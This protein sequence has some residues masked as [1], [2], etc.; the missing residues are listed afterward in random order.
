MSVP[1]SMSPSATMNSRFSTPGGRSPNLTPP[2]VNGGGVGGPG[3]VFEKAN[4]V[5]LSCPDG[6]AHALSEQNIRL[7]QLIYEHKVSGQKSGVRDVK[8]RATVID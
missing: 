3:A 6:L 4:N 2:E 8:G 5:I 1:F 7:Q